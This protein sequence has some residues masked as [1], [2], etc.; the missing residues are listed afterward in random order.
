MEPV[1]IGARL[2][3]SVVGPLIKRLFVVDGVGAGLVDRP[4]RISSMVTFRGEKRIL[5]DSELRKIAEELVERA[6]V[7][8]SSPL[9]WTMRRDGSTLHLGVD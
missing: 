4:V 9:P 7:W 6:A 2:A 5:T 3:S 1:S 8:I